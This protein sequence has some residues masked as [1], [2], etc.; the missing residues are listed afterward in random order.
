MNINEKKQ[1]AG[2]QA[3]GDAAGDR[4]RIAMIIDPNKMSCG[5]DLPR[6][7]VG[8]CDCK[9]EPFTATRA[10]LRML[11]KGDLFT[12]Y[13]RCL[14]DETSPIMWEG[15]TKTDILEMFLDGRDSVELTPFI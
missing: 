15:F 3:D 1:I 14:N 4:R 2:A 10:D 6:G 9:L 13:I 11:N 7:G 8:F 5:C 12:L